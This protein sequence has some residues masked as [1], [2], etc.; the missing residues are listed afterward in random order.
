[1]ISINNSTLKTKTGTLIKNDFSYSIDKGITF[2][3]FNSLTNEAIIDLLSSSNINYLL[4]SNII[5]PKFK[6][7]YSI[8]S[9]DTIN[10]CTLNLT[11]I[12]NNDSFTLVTLAKI[13]DNDYNELFAYDVLSNFTEYYYYPTPIG[14]QI[15]FIIICCLFIIAI[16]IL[17]IIFKH[18]DQLKCPF[19]N[20]KDDTVLLEENTI[21]IP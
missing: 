2:L 11:N 19:G 1:M 20:K 6:Y 9:E 18:F 3:P 4:V 8:S 21:L 10:E 17:L 14:L 15:T 13:I 7:E 16:F 5:P 12:Y